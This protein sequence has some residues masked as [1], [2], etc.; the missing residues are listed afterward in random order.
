MAAK[1]RSYSSASF[2][3]SFVMWY[4][5]SWVGQM[6]G[7]QL[8]CR[9]LAALQSTSTAELRTCRDELQRIATA[10]R[11]RLVQEELCT[12]LVEERLRQVLHGGL[13]TLSDCDAA[14]MFSGSGGLAASSPTSLSL[15][16]SLVSDKVCTKNGRTA[17][18]NKDSDPGYVHLNS[19]QKQPGAVRN[20]VV[21]KLC[22]AAGHNCIRCIADLVG[23]GV[24]IN[25][26]TLSG[27]TARDW[28][29]GYSKREAL[30]FVESLGGLASGL[31]TEGWK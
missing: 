19:M 11:S 25:S 15:P 1:W 21:Y 9:V 20:G 3:L 28:A 13:E 18:Q 10:T 27:Y 31:P 16:L 4:V 14:S 17:A 8:T 30:A 29:V 5:R 23:L 7:E 2:L 12:K 6:P 22:A 26:K 24:C